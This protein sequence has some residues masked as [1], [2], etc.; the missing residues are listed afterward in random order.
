MSRDDAREA[1]LLPCLGRYQLIKRL[2]MGGMAEIYLARA[3]GA[4]G[5]AK[6]VVIKR[7][8]ASRAEDPEHVALFVE[9]ARLAARLSHANL[10]QIFDFEEEPGG[11]FYM[12]MEYVHGRDLREVLD[13]CAYLGRRLGDVRA[14]HLAVEVLQGLTYAHEVTRRGRPLEIVHRD[15]SPRNVLVG[16]NGDVK[17]TDFGI[18]LG[19]GLGVQEE[20]VVRGKV[21]YMSPEQVRG[22]ALDHRSDHYSMALVIYEMLTG[23]RALAGADGAP[24]IVRTAKAEFVP[25][26]E[27]RPDLPAPLLDLMQRAL[28]FRAEDRF[29]SGREF[30]HALRAVLLQEVRTPTELEVGA[31]LTELFPEVTDLTITLSAAEAL[32]VLRESSGVE[33][34]ARLRDALRSGAEEDDSLGPGTGTTRPDRNAMP[35]EGSVELPVADSGSLPRAAA[36][37]AV[38]ALDGAA[39]D[40]D[41]TQPQRAPAPADLPPTVLSPRVDPSG[42][43]DASPELLA[44]VVGPPAILED[45]GAPSPADLA[46][47]VLGAQGAA[48]S[49]GSGLLSPEPATSTAP[50]DPGVQDTLADSPAPLG[51]AGAAAPLSASTSPPSVADPFAAPTE[52]T[53]AHTPQ[54][55][56]ALASEE[57]TT[58]ALSSPP[59]LGRRVLRWALPLGLGVFVVAGVLG[60]RGL[61][62]RAGSGQSGVPG[63][64]ST[65][66]VGSPPAS[67]PSSDVPDASGP[68]AALP[69]PGQPAGDP[70]QPE[71]SHRGPA[72]RP[73]RPPLPERPEP[74]TPR[75]AAGTARLTVNATPYARLWVDGVGPHE[76]PWTAVLPSGPHRLRLRNTALG[77]ERSLRVT[78]RPGDA[79]VRSFD[80]LPRP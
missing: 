36:A 64:P 29:V 61:S 60:V 33:L 66:D 40:E 21:L 2:A 34:S 75:P 12:A 30:L 22:Q 78:L 26:A 65:A 39:T 10:T 59:G 23:R 25:L 53:P 62:R 13:R 35:A 43:P 68:P 72:R 58:P 4:E 69:P 45:P 70:A 50:T 20:G 42:Q 77:T 73:R 46:A 19:R 32:L 57:A 79:Q 15:I 48:A 74:G 28:A 16:F 76:T 31:L 11:G 49:A 52:L 51:E 17:L 80:M 9:E 56:S 5:F 71:S 3:E 18:A 8:L 6:P 7:I 54:P 14:L 27:L 41:T 1:G 47:T 44:T 55:V 38:A 67:E 37:Q 24:S 63:V